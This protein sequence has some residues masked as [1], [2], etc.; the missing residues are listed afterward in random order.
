M[1][2]L[3]KET[4]VSVR[5]SRPSARLPANP[6][7]SPDAHVDTGKSGSPP[8]AAAPAAAPAA[9][10]PPVAGPEHRG[11]YADFFG[12]RERPF[13]LLPDPELLLWSQQYRR[14]FSV[15]EF[16]VMSRSPITLM[17]G[18]IGCGKTTLLRELLA[19]LDNTLTVGL[20]SNAQGGRGALIQW[21]LNAL[22]QS[23]DPNAGYVH[24][25]QAM[26]N[27]MIAEYAAGRR[28]LL[29]FD[30]AQNLSQESL[31]ELRMLTNINTGKDEVVQLVLIGQ[32]ELRD[33]IR[34]PNLEQLAQRIAVSFHLDPLDRD[35][36]TA[37]IKHR[38]RAVGGS[39]EEFTEDAMVHV[40]EVTRGVPRL[41][42]QFC[43]MALLYAWTR[44]KHQVTRAILGQVL[45]DNIFFA[46]QAPTQTPT[47]TTVKAKGTAPATPPASIS[48]SD[49]LSGPA[50]GPIS[51][52]ISGPASEG[53][54]G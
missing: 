49:P 33:M 27:F 40:H 42:N 24:L 48:A 6:P 10:P 25:F 7:T 18:A 3:P 41:I 45:A 16:G 44:E 43:D 21:V 34:Q 54:P 11:F 22:G 29:I 19:H 36:T 17:T 37:F 47:Q 46:A 51:G 8:P 35:T 1:A 32:P 20:I 9:G 2:K 52:P 14:A 53:N 23:F 13:T 15:L 12:F 31:E 30:E 4:P 26:Q 38:L 28:T 50:S 5:P 39:G